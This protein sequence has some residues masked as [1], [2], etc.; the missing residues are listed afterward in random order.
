LLI[1]AL[2]SNVSEPIAVSGPTRVGV[3]TVRMGGN[4]VGLLAR[5]TICAPLRHRFLGRDHVRM[6]E[7]P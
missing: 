5:L 2:L 4:I 6:R 7:L 3:R 1:R